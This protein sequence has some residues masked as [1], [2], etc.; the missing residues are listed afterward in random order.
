MGK[1]VQNRDLI[2]RLD[3]ELKSRSIPPTLKYVKGHAG[4]HG[5]E[6]ADRLA[7]NGSLQDFVKGENMEPPASDEERSMPTK[8]IPKQRKVPQS[9]EERIAEAAKAW[10]D[11]GFSKEAALRKATNFLK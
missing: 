1:E 4:I 8:V 2:R 10:Q 9:K 6:M 3:R 11:A 5:N 7:V